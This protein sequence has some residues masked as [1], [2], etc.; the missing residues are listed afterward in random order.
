MFKFTIRELLLLTLIVGLGLGWALRERHWRAEVDR[1]R[2]WRTRAGALEVALRMDGWK[3]SWDLKAKQ[4]HTELKEFPRK[5]QSVAT[6]F[7]EPSIRD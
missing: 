5:R 6:D 1:A 2:Q 3:V 4:V 7:Y